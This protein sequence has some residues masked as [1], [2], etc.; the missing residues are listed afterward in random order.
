MRQP[1]IKPPPSPLRRRGNKGKI[2]LLRG[3]READG[4]EIFKTK[5]KLP[6]PPQKG[7]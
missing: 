3:G 7:E 6:L 1:Q 5:C 2:P 4:V